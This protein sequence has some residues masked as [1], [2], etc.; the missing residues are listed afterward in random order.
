MTR[1]AKRG[2]ETRTAVPRR[3]RTQ[4]ARARAIAVGVIGTGRMGL[5]IVG[6][7]ARKRFS[8]RA[9]DL[10]PGKA[11]GVVR[12]GAAWCAGP[13]ELARD[14]EVI[15]CC[16]GYEAELLDLLVEQ[17]ML[18]AARPGAIIAVLSTVRPGTIGELARRAARSGVHVVDATL[19][20][21]PQAA[22][23]GTLLAF[24]GGEPEVVER[25]RPV[26]AAFCTDIVR[27]GAPG[28]AQVAKAA[29][30][31]ILWSCLVAD[32]EALALAQRFGVDHD[33]LR[34]ALVTSSAD[35]F[36]LRNWGTN[37]MAWADDDLKIVAD[38]AAQASISLPQAGLV[39]EICRVLRPRRFRL[40]DYGR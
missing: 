34:S 7:L 12:L 35:N 5:P 26:L 15:L 37:E 1:I 8:V 29:N 32:H 38:M 16:V 20:R 33:A 28:S 27:T 3:Q 11:A 23:A 39:R 40:E 14:C 22:D 18:E 31:L 24:V 6:H 25:L 9:H 19:C 13:S 2:R 17:G 36:A 4:S 21:G 30:N 10:D